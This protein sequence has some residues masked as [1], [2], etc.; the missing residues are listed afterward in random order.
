MKPQ[1]RQIIFATALML[2]CTA[3]MARTSKDCSHEIANLKKEIASLEKER[4]ALSRKVI[5]R[6][7]EKHNAAGNIVKRVGKLIEVNRNFECGITKGRYHDHVNPRGRY[8]YTAAC[9]K[10]RTKYIEWEDYVR[11]IPECEQRM[12][13][14]EEIKERI[15]EIKDEISELNK[16]RAQLLRRAQE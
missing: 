9:S 12:A 8:D 4:N 13:R 5:V 3:A 6:Y 2:V 11:Q 1:G 7:T 14:L 16:E 15:V 10:C